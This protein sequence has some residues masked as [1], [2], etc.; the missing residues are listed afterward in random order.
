MEVISQMVMVPVSEIK[1]YHRNARNNEETVKKL[2]ELIPRVGFNVPL[3]LD[4]N[5]V[6]VK[7]HTRW[8]AAIRLGMK[9]LPCVYSD[10]DEETLKLDRIADNKVAEFSTWNMEMLMSE[11]TSINTDYDLSSLNL[12]FDLP[13]FDVVPPT[14]TREAVAAEAVRPGDIP[15]A[16]GENREP[17]KDEPFITAEDV[18]KTVS[19]NPKE[20][21][22]VVCDKCGH[23]LFFKR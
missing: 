16:A 10:A 15:P 4:R 9:E 12:K 2:V 21:V 13:S 23:H 8:T 19:F 17:V 14:P 6:I 22:E 3:L 5:N 20:Y 18:K 7:G 1:P 11:L